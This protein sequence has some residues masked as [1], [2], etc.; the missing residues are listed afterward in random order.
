MQHI[1]GALAFLALKILKWKLMVENSVQISIS[2][3]A[4][5]QN[6]PLSKRATWPGQQLNW[7]LETLTLEQQQI[8]GDKVWPVW[9]ILDFSETDQKALIQ[10]ST[11]VALS[12]AIL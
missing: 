8:S 10:S 2:H 12:S 4:L 1:L 3:P 9:M 11:H 5:R 6:T 7:D